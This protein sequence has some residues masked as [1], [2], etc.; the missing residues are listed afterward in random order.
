MKKLSYLAMLLIGLYSD[1]IQSQTFTWGNPFSSANET[2]STLQHYVSNGVFQIN[3]RYNDKI[4]NKEVAVN[5]LD[6]AKLD[7]IK[8]IDLSLKQPVMGLNTAS[9]LEVFQENGVNFIMFTDDFNTKTKEREL[10]YQKVNIE[11]GVKTEPVLITKMPT[12]NSN[13]Y[14]ARSD[15]KQF[16]GVI[17]SYSL[18][19]KANEKMNVAVFDKDFKAAGE[20]SYDTPYIN[21]KPNEQNFYV[22]NQGNI[23]IVKEI[24]LA[25]EKPFKTIYF[26]DKSQQTMTETSLKFDNDYQLSTYKGQFLNDDFYLQGL[27][28]RIG[29]KGIQLYRG[30]LPPTNGIYAAKFNQKGEKV[31]IEKN[32]TGEIISLNIKD[33]VFDGMKTWFFGDL[34]YIERKNKP[35]VPGQTF[36]FEYDYTYSNEGIVFGKLDNE[37]GKLEW[38]KNVPFSEEKTVNDNGRFLSYLYFVRNNQLTILYNDTQKTMLGK[39]TYNDRFIT[40]EVY[41]DRGNPVSKSLIPD[42]GLELT[43]IPQYDTVSEN[44]DLDTSVNVYVQDGKYILRAKSPSNEKYGYLKF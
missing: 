36:N 26:W 20:I 9:I 15:N 34:T 23:F 19:K 29:S 32:E 43:Y 6:I 42:N 18:D 31:Y 7:K 8:T 35:V 41:D 11:T 14:I 21:K 12:R 16:Y 38:F 25:K 33:F 5:N 3:I 17:K 10:Y 2:G 22:S 27:Y 1:G 37:T 24:D 30:G 28:T 13:Y 44:F 39:R 40:I 4:F